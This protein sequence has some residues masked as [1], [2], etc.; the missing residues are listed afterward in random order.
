MASIP[1]SSQHELPAF[2]TS[3]PGSNIVRIP[4]TGEPAS[5]V[6]LPEPLHVSET[7]PPEALE[8]HSPHLTSNEVQPPSENSDAVTP[9]ADDVEQNTRPVSQP[10]PY[11]PPPRRPTSVSPLRRV[12]LFFGFGR[13]NKT[14]RQ[15]VSFVLALTIDFSEVRLMFQ[16]RLKD[17]IDL[18]I[19]LDL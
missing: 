10:R 3:S 12:L 1:R 14:R 2:V 15:L 19:G 9:S 17:T 16:S 7:M 8:A 4:H 6:A 18:P 5:P 11:I 13:D